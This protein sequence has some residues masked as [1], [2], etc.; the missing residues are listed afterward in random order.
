MTKTTLSMPQAAVDKI[1][2]DPQAFLAY[3]NANGFADLVAVLGPTPLY[4]H[5]IHS[6]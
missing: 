5:I 2:A 1:M 3:A 6:D 4:L